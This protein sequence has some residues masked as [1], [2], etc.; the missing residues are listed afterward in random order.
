MASSTLTLTLTL[1][2]YERALLGEFYN[3]F[4]CKPTKAEDDILAND[5]EFTFSHWLW[6]RKV[7]DNFRDITHHSLGDVDGS[8]EKFWKTLLH[9]LHFYIYNFLYFRTAALQD[10]NPGFP[11]SL[12]YSSEVDLSAFEAMLSSNDLKY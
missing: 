12:A 11:Q 10:D 9:A 5:D 2:P 6:R 8:M 3:A 1:D 4:G 7:V